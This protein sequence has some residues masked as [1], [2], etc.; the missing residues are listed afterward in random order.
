MVNTKKIEKAYKAADELYSKLGVDADKAIKTL[1]SISLSLHCWQGDDVSGFEKPGARLEG[2]GLQVT[3][4]YPGKARTVDELRLDLK[5]AYSLI[6]GHH[7]LN[8]HA[9]YG[10]FKGKP[11]DRDEIGPEHF[12]GWVEWAK[13]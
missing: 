2:G 9:I 4:S 10:E 11:V 6:P 13:S 5:K 1:E 12:K 7:R 3:G 8:L